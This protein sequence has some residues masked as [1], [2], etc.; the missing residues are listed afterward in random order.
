MIILYK[1]LKYLI[2]GIV[3]EMKM[4]I[5]SGKKERKQIWVWTCCSMTI[6]RILH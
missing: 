1:K 6:E 4:G 3:H 2:T 5:E